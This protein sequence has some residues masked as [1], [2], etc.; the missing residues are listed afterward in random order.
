MLKQNQEIEARL[1]SV[2][3]ELEQLQLKLRTS[4][5]VANN[6]EV[7]KVNPEPEVVLG[8]E[9]V[10]TTD[11]ETMLHIENDDDEDQDSDIEMDF[12]PSDKEQASKETDNL[13]PIDVAALVKRVLNIL[14]TKQI[15]RFKLAT[16]AMCIAPRYMTS[17]LNK[18]T[19]W[20]KCTPYRK[21]LYRKLLLWSESSEAIEEL[22]VQKEREGWR[23]HRPKTTSLPEV[24]AEPLDTESIAFK[25]RSLFV[26][27]GL[28][29]RRMARDVLGL[30][31]QDVCQMLLSPKPW[32]E[33]T[34]YR[35]SKRGIELF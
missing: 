8:L 26:A 1:R 16:E 15:S 32:A 23:W 24:S 30:H 25:A 33:C 35:K 2:K 5:I 12:D 4:V 27:M 21:R 7:V 17:L 20:E 31:G 11:R 3:A 6:P 22:L 28:S 14:Q 29:K 34:S 18:E 13:A 9:P 10:T 19:R